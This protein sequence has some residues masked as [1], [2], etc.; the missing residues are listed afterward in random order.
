[1]R[2][3]KQP[4]QNEDQGAVQAPQNAVQR[5]SDVAHKSAQ[6]QQPTIQAKQRPI[7]RK[8]GYQPHQAKHQPIQRKAQNNDLKTQMSNQYGVDLSG[9]KEHSNSSF[10]GSVNALATIQGKDIHYAPGQFTEQN[11]KHELGHAI[12]N[13]LNGTPK[14]DKVVNGQVVD[15]TR[16]QAADKIAET[17]LQRKSN[18]VE[19]VVM[20]NSPHEN[21]VIQR[22]KK[23]KVC[24]AHPESWGDIHTVFGNAKQGSRYEGT[25]TGGEIGINT[26]GSAADSS[27]WKQLYT[28][29]QQE[30]GVKWIRGH[31]KNDNLGG[32]GN[33]S[34]NITPLPENINKQ[35]S[36]QFEQPVK[37]LVESLEGSP[38]KLKINVETHGWSKQF[39]VK[40]MPGKLTC[41]AELV[42]GS[43]S[44][45]N[46][47]Q[48]GEWNKI[49]TK[50]SY[51]YSDAV[52]TM[53]SSSKK[54]KKNKKGFLAV[55]GAGGP[56]EAAKKKAKAKTQVKAAAKK[57][58][59]KK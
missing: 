11:R 12:D 4:Q 24:K 8:Q 30:T 37:K 44:D 42:D 53:Q 6:G 25:F 54:T 48:Q 34:E 5:Q 46:K 47:Y 52:K 18:N 31:L 21:Q 38:I 43:E 33:E 40:E 58:K 28:K 36:A 20:L 35:M 22:L 32:K 9:F 51:N 7:Q 57:V 59:G 19:P 14:G 17:P 10:P 26:G 49:T 45:L 50:K 27:N 56:K 1:M 2:T 3:Q 39:G 13:T 29:L 16:E 41:T 23:S 15:T 55:K